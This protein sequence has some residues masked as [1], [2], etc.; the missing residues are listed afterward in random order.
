M[1]GASSAG[2]WASTSASSALRAGPGSTPSS[3]ESSS[4]ARR[5]AASASAWRWA[6]YST[7]VLT[8]LATWWRVV[9][10]D[11]PGQP[12]LSAAGQPVDEVAGYEEWLANV[13]DHLRQRHPQLPLV[14]AGHSRGAAAALL[15]TPRTS[16]ARAGQPRRSRPGPAVPSHVVAEH[17]LA[18]TTDPCPFRATHRHDA[19]R[20]RRGVRVTGPVADVGRPVDADHRRPRPAPH[21][22][23]G[24]MAR[25]NV[26]AL[27][28]ERDVF[29]TPAALTE[30]V[31]RLGTTLDVVPEAGHL[32]VDQRPDLVV[33]ACSEVLR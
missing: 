33:T 19:R 18:A 8:R 21:R 27:V 28:G 11:L 9:C 16:T 26:R 7:A 24:A 22:R 10:P 31:R 2:D 14:L 32:L 30:P 3:S 20:Q 5:S 17:R 23:A 4:R 1:P 6:R 13:M 29:F 25:Q 15:A 12:G